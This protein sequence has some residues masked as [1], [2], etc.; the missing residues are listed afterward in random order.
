MRFFQP[1][2]KLILLAAL[3]A[4]LSA[5]ASPNFAYTAKALVPLSPGQG[6]GVATS[7]NNAGVACGS[8]FPTAHGFCYFHGV[9]ADIAPFPGDF[10][11][12]VTAINNTGAVVGGSSGADPDIRRA[13]RYAHGRMTDLGTLDRPLAGAA[14]IND[15]GSVVGSARVGDYYN[16][17]FLYKN[18]VMRSLGTMH[19][20]QR[21]G[22]VAINNHGQIVGGGNIAPDFEPNSNDVHAFF[23]ENGVMNDLGTLGGSNSVANS[24]NE[25]GQV[26]G[27]SDIAPV[28]SGQQRAFIYTVKK[29]MRD[30]GTLPNGAST[31]ANAINNRGEVVG[32][33]LSAEGRAFLYQPGVG[34]RDLTDMLDPASGWV[35]VYATSINDHGQIVGF[36]CKQA[37]CGPVQVD[38]VAD[39]D[40]RHD[41]RADED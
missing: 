40:C 34:M 38:P 6:S 24:I 1:H 31:R 17:A 22:A 19:G 32:A 27:T 8:N 4:P 41:I 36:G 2:F 9:L 33:S 5:P 37:L 30:L 14:G 35:I 21:S 39:E 13:F 3:A 15:A 29:G 11:S 23:Y 26:A 16:V 18:G 28:D 7:I 25:R 10:N 20:A 12:Y